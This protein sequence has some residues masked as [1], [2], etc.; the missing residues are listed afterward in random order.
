M[1]Q[2]TFI[3]T[4]T[5]VNTI[6][7]KNENINFGVLIPKNSAIIIIDETENRITFIHQG[8]GKQNME[9]GLFNS[10]PKKYRYLVKILLILC[11]YHQLNLKK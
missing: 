10:I 5:F 9:K 4:E 7:D 6:K 1:E 11:W 8:H 3:T 2:K